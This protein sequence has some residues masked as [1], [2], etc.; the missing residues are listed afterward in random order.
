MEKNNMIDII[1]ISNIYPGDPA[2]V[3]YFI[4]TIIYSNDINRINMEKNILY[5]NKNIIF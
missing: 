2:P 3:E 1:K 5:N 4:G